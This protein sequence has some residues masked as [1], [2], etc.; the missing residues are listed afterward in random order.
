MA[1]TYADQNIIPGTTR[2][3]V[4]CRMCGGL[5]GA[6][7]NPDGSIALVQ[8]GCPYCGEL[9]APFVVTGQ[10]SRVETEIEGA[11][12]NKAPED[13]ARKLADPQR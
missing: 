4:A 2:G 6:L 7:F 11:D 3:N 5:V 8:S 1:V 9:F 12:S 13:T 10:N